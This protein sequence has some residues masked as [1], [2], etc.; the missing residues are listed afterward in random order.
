M[1]A[2][3]GLTVVTSDGE[4]EVVRA[5]TKY[6]KDLVKT[7]MLNQLNKSDRIQF[8]RRVDPSQKYLRD[9]YI[10]ISREISKAIS[11]E[12]VSRQIRR[13]K[14]KSS[15]PIRHLRFL[16][17]LPQCLTAAVYGYHLP[18]KVLD[19]LVKIM[20]EPLY[21]NEQQQRKRETIS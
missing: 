15:N 20:D 11:V 14:S 9:N 17:D 12:E 5:P 7:L 13:L 21:H 1:P 8:V 6:T 16:P 3:V 18:V 4:L 10:R 19:G 2:Y